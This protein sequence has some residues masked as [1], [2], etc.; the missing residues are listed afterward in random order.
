MDY[1]F[2]GDEGSLGSYADAVDFCWGTH[3]LAG[4]RAWLR[5]QYGSL[6]ALN[7][8][9]GE[10]LPRL[11][12]RPA[13]HHRGGPARGP[14]R[15]LGGPPHLHGGLLRPGVPDGSRRRPRGRPGGPHRPLRHPGHE[16]LE[17]L[18]LAPARRRDRR[19]P[20]VLR[21]EPVGHPPLVREAGRP[22]RLLDRLRAQRRR[23][24]ARGVD[25]RPAGRPAPAAVLEPVDRQP[26]HDL[27]ALGPRPRRGLQ[28][29]ALRGDR[30]AADGGGAPRRRGG[31]PL[32]DALRPRRGHPRPPRP[33]GGEEGGHELPGEPGRVGGPPRRPGP[34]V[35][36]RGGAPGRG[37]GSPGEA[38]LRPAVLDGALGPRGGRDPP[39]RGGGRHP[40][41]RRRGRPLRRARGLARDGG[42]RRALRRDGP[43]S[44]DEREGGGTGERARPRHGGGLGPGPAGPGPRLARGAGARGARGWGT[45]A[46][47]RRRS[48]PR[49]REPGREGPRRVPERSPRPP[50]RLARRVACGP[51]RRALRCG[52]AARGRGHR[53]RPG[54]P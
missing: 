17:R 34:V 4:F 50:G 28:G 51:A 18:R 32:L 24:E 20:L 3:T 22:H 52:R 39:L 10:C 41:R 19:L 40:P 11:G 35:P 30:P 47:A 15:P 14:L 53:P 1:Y 31:H 49:G 38:R 37:G 48:R 7:R 23:G 43:A 45:G 5:E 44:A 25:G 29:A 13:P 21:R 27:L 54:G 6:D 26:G 8:V 9:V 2:V 16:P 36:L 33:R 46:G 12:R 42:A